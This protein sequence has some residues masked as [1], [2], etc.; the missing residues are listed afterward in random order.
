MGTSSSKSKAHKPSALK[1]LLSPGPAHQAEPAGATN[2]TPPAREAV[3][4]QPPHQ[5][6]HPTPTPT[7]STP[8]EEVEGSDLTTKY[9]RGFASEVAL[10]QMMDGGSTEYNIERVLKKRAKQGKKRSKAGVVSD[11]TGLYVDEQEREE[12]RRLLPR[13]E[14]KK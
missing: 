6:R 1:R 10:L 5:A 2:S 8:P 9:G 4:A 3:E 11:S 14:N 13:G 7:P 12:H